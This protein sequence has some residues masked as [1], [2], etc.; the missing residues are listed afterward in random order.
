VSKVPMKLIPAPTA[1]LASLLVAACGTGVPLPP[2]AAHPA[3]PVSLAQL[4]APP[5]IYHQRGF[6]RVSG[7]CRIEFEGN[8]LYR[9]RDARTGWSADRAVWLDLGWPVSDEI[10]ALDA[11]HVTVEGRFNTHNRGHEGMYAGA[12]E[13]IRRIERSPPPEH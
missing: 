3:D 10:R 2:V 12:I 11:E 5:L 9:S 8:S 7:W 13:D 1:V 4:L 6:V